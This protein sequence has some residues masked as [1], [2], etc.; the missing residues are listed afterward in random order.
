M[1]LAVITLRVATNHDGWDAYLRKAALQSEL[2]RI[3]ALVT[4]LLESGG[5]DDVPLLTWEVEC[6][7]R[8]LA[9]MDRIRDRDHEIAIMVDAAL[10]LHPR[11]SGNKCGECTEGPYYDIQLLAYP[12]PTREALLS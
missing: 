9:E 8:E 3:R 2:A 10:E 5:S 1:G 4:P 11:I 12:C 6:I 7:E